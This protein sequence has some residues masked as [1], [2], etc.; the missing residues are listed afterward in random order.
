MVRGEM[1]WVGE[2]RKLGEMGVLGVEGEGR[3]GD[4]I[5]CF[6]GGYRTGNREGIGR[7][8]AGEG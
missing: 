1:G 5:V 6:K 3:G 7:E 2:R 4:G 8:S